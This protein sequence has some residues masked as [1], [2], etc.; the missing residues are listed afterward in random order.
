MSN[1]RDFLRS[2][3]RGASLI[4]LSPTVPGFLSNTAQAATPELDA[5]IL[6]VIQLDGG[7]DGINT[8]VP[9]RD[10]GYEKYRKAL[11]LPAEELLKVADG[12]GLHPSLDGAVK[13]LES[14]RL[15]IVP[16]VG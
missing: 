4:A 6:V 5:R 1:R 7:N 15:A 14:G 9:F 13:L 2:S 16:G 8:V 10:H 12:I 11:R 3:F